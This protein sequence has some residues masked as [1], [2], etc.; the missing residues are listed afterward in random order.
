MKEVIFREYDIRGIVGTELLLDQVYDLARAIAYYFKQHS[1]ELNTI[2]LGMDGRTHSPAIKNEIVRAITDAGLNVI[3]V[4]LCPT[5]AFYFALH[6]YPVDAGIMITASHN[7]KEY[8]GL[9]ICLGTA[10]IWGTELQK[11]K[12]LYVEKKHLPHA[13]PGTLTDQPIIP[14][15]ITWLINHF[16]DLKK[17]EL[18]FVIDCGNGTAGTVI[19]ELIKKMEWPNVTL[20]YEEVD[21][22]YPNHEADPTVERNMEDAK[23]LLAQSNAQFGVG[24][25]GDC[26]RMA[27]MT[28]KGFLIPGDQLLAVF[29]RPIIEQHPVAGIV[30]DIKSSAGLIELLERWDATPIMSPSGH[31]IIK[32]MMFEHH[33]L[34][35][36]ELSCHFFFKDRYFGYDDGIYALLRLLEIMQRTGKTLS[37]LIAVFPHRYSSTELRLSCPE[38]KK[39]SIVQEIKKKI[40]EQYPD[41]Q[42]ITLDGIRASFPFGWGIIR[43]SNTQAVLSMRFESDTKEGLKKVITLFYELLQPYLDSIEL[44]ELTQAK[45]VI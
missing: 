21:G 31:S 27:A 12:Q 37:E 35:G 2:A 16:S 15:Y 20:L 1:S 3:F 28:K 22:T 6:T 5:P 34:L 42:I 39:R 32:D 11:I 9:K 25:D 7:T 43:A 36:G 14:E 23:N 24:F 29:A 38:D 40:E 10:S 30:F 4:G 44:K 17:L 18:P 13:D 41:T 26:D 33:A 45:E 8:N 19:P